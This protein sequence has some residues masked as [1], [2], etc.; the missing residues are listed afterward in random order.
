MSRQYRCWWSGS[1]DEAEF[2]KLK[3]RAFFKLSRY[4]YNCF[5]KELCPKFEGN[6]G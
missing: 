5:V 1:R 2:K 3:E 4:T 6:S